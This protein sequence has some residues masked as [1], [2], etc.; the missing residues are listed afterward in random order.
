M[1]S[2]GKGDN[3]MF[4]QIIIGKP[5]KCPNRMC[6]APFFK[7][8]FQGYMLSS[9]MEVLCIMKCE[10]CGDQFAIRQPISIVQEYLTELPSKPKRNLKNMKPIT[11]SD[12]LEMRKVLDSPTALSDILGNK[13][14]L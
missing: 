9:E 8:A 3:H 7:D 5:K 14:D 4:N 13:L 10:A 1:Y 2:F 12:V 11:Q 6:R